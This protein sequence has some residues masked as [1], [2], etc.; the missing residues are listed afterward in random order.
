M[1]KG[2]TNTRDGIDLDFLELKK[3]YLHL[4]FTVYVSP[5][6]HIDTVEVT[7]LDEIILTIKDDFVNM[8]N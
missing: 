2:K 3:W 6:T 8:K 1:G 5:E 7:G 4:L